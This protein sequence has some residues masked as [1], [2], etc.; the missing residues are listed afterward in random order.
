[1]AHIVIADAG[2]LI[3][4]A[5]IDAL[6]VLQN[7]FSEISVA[8]S[9]KCECLSKPGKDAQRIETAIDEGWLLIFP[10]GHIAEP[11]SPSLGAGE[12]DSIRYALK[13]PEDSLL[14]V[15]DRL[16]RRFAIKQG[17]NIIGTARLLDLAEQRGLIEGAEQCI[18]EMAAIGYRI[19]LKLLQQ[20]RSE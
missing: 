17:I 10:P 11:L 7:L 14:I 3:A 9:V 5:N 1:M 4:F 12:S 13:S 6:W 18:S 20:I 2:P 15:D 16:A 8:E 19:S